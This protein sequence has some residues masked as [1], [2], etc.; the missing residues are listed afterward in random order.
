MFF[1]NKIIII[2]ENKVI[3]VK[4]KKLITIDIKDKE[5]IEKKYKNKIILTGD[6]NTNKNSI[7]TIHLLINKIDINSP[8]GIVVFNEQKKKVYLYKLGSMI[9][10]YDYENLENLLKIKKL[11]KILKDNRIIYTKENFNYYEIIK[12]ANKI[13]KN[14]YFNI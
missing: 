9:E 10:K 8:Q 7:I 5:N 11:E 12:E 14:P 2:D 13:C 6:N 3:K 1:T 4:G